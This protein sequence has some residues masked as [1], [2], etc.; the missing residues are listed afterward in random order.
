MKR[1]LF[2]LVIALLCMAPLHAQNTL[3]GRVT[4]QPDN[5]PLPGVNIVFPELLKGTYS[6]GNGNYFIKDLP[7]GRY[8]VKFSFIGYET[9]IKPVEFK[10]KPVT[11]NVSLKPAVIQ[12]Q[13]VVVTGSFTEAQHK[14]S[15][16]I[17]TL[18]S[19]SIAANATP[20]FVNVLTQVPGVA[21][22]SKGPGVATP[23]I[24]GLSTSNILLLN[25][26][27]R[28]ENF[29]FSENHPYMIDGSGVDR[30]E[31]IKGPASLI[32]GSGAVGGVI[33]VIPEPVAPQNSIRGDARLKLHSNTQ[34]INGSFGLQGNSKGII[35]GVRGAVNSNKDYRQGNNH[36]APNTRFNRNS[37]KA[38]VGLLK[39]KGA[40]RI[41]YE[42]NRAKLGMA[43]PPALQLVTDNE[44]KNRVWYQDLESQMITSDNK[45]FFDKIKAA[46]LFSFQQ[47][48][49]RLQGSELTPARTL[50]DMNLKTFSYTLKADYTPNENFGV[51]FG[52]QG[53]WQ[54]NKN[55]DAPDHV[56]PDAEKSGFSAFAVAKYNLKDLFIPEAG[57][58]F[59]HNRIAVPAHDGKETIDNKYDNVSFSLGSVIN[60]SER[61]L[62]RLNAASSFRNP[63]IAELTQD[64]LHGAR[65]ETGNP[66]L[67]NQRNKEADIGLHAHTRHFTMGLNLF[68]NNIDNYIYLEKTGDT[69][70]EGYFIYRYNQSG[71]VLYGGEATVHLHPHPW[72]WLHLK[73]SYAY[74]LGKKEDDSYL[75]MIPANKLYGEIM[76]KAKRWKGFRESYARLACNYVFA[77][78]HPSEFEEPSAAYTLVSLSAGTHILLSDKRMI[79][80]YLTADNLLNTAYTDHLST[81]RDV[82]L[83]NMGRN[84]TLTV[85]IP[86]GVSLGEQ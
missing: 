22:I 79:E 39:K 61:F 81:L 30:V 84:I 16:E 19:K 37:L 74:I 52:V 15:I 7:N 24:R 46:A 45:M 23:V 68:Y 1:Y 70:Q 2:S 38:D 36:T 75:P 73:A 6:D 85:K 54:K 14:N 44:R 43:V 28:L 57:I 29:Q 60:L 26:G 27:V 18:N 17:N 76:V 47:N 40:Y 62:I 78:N 56:I 35:F 11:L 51:N 5:K 65:Y 72:D 20:S 42:Y 12:G 86:F 41:F 58:R 3:S 77:Q 4:G 53:L 66:A 33:N 25:N 34:G 10:G 67:K 80:L 50:V 83:F 13:E 9:V 32:Y 71:A 55:G 82:N 21:V 59:D 8:L 69:T 31:I 63:N 64:G 48:H 49:R